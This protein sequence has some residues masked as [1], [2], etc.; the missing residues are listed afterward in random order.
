MSR[1]K[2]QIS[3]AQLS[4]FLSDPDSVKLF[5]RLFAVADSE[6]SEVGAGYVLH[7]NG[8]LECWGIVT[9]TSADHTVTLPKNY[10]D[11]SYNIQISAQYAAGTWK[12]AEPRSS[13]PPT[14]SEFHVLTTDAGVAASG[15]TFYWR[16]IGFWR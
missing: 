14:A 16:T 15:V 13:T 2:L 5:E 1:A 7:N 9:S 6:D 4:A 11:G 3:R 8:V 12:G 10:K